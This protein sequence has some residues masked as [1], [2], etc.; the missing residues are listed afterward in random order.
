[1]ADAIATAGNVKKAA[2][3]EAVNPLVEDGRKLI[4]NVTRVFSAKSDMY[5]YL[6]AYEPDATATARPL[7]AYVTF[8]QG[9]AKVMETPPVEMTEGWNPKSQMLPLK[10]SFPL[11]NLG[12]G[13]YDCELTVLDP[14]GRKAAFWQAPVMVIP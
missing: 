14:D 10:L 3:T 4:P 13:E 7:L 11:G 6:Q 1:M 5:V 9:S 2:I 8:F 12:P